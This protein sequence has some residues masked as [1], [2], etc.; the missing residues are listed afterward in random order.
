MQ[1]SNSNKVQ[2]IIMTKSRR[3]TATASAIGLHQKKNWS[4][5]SLVQET[6]IQNFFGNIAFI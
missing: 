4:F 3:K 5:C 1:V 2:F 6:N